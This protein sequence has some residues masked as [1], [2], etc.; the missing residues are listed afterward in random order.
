M[1]EKEKFNIAWKKIKAKSDAV[2]GS[3][4]DMTASEADRVLEASGIDTEELRRAAYKRIYSAAQTYWNAHKELPPRLKQALKDLRPDDLP[5][6]TESEA[7]HQ[8]ESILDRVMRPFTL[9]NVGVISYSYRAKKSVS[10]DDQAALDRLEEKL[11]RRL[12][13]KERSDEQS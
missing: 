2:V 9:Q 7:T 10:S 13:Q 1:D 12:R 5:A 11:N 3:A 6:Q 8:A 4:E